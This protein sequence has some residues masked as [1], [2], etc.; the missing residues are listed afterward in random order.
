[1]LEGE[2]GVFGKQMLLGV[3]TKNLGFSDRK[4]GFRS[5]HFLPLVLASLSLGFLLCKM[6]MGIE[7]PSKVHHSMEFQYPEATRFQEY[8][9][10]AKSK[11][12]LC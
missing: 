3:R 12:T 10:G 7:L 4:L 11:R 6:R 8:E 9:M 2:V 5:H 1:M